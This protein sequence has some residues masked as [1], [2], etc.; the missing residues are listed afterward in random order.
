MR[1][2]PSLQK[3]ISFVRIEKE[4]VLSWGYLGIPGV[5]SWY[6]GKFW[7]GDAE[8]SLD[9]VFWLT[10]SLGLEWVIG[11]ALFDGGMRWVVRGE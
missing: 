3:G 4:V 10:C 8:G 6:I 5:S 2:S 1:T 7:L 9:V 11:M